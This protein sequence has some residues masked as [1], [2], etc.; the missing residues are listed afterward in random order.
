MSTRFDDSELPVDLR[1]SSSAN[2]S[3]PRPGVR[4]DP[5]KHRAAGLTPGQ[6]MR[7]EYPEVFGRYSGPV[8]RTSQKGSIQGIASETHFARCLGPTGSPAEPIVHCRDE[9]RFYRYDPDEGVYQDLTEHE[10]KRHIGELLHRCAEG[11]K[12]RS[13]EVHELDR[14]VVKRN[15]REALKEQVS[16]SS[17]RFTRDIARLPVANGM[18]DLQKL[19]LESHSPKHFSRWKLSAPWKDQFGVPRRFMEFLAWMFPSRQDRRLAV[20][21]LAMAISGNPAQRLVLLTGDGGTGKSTFIHLLGELVGPRAFGELDLANA[22]Q[23]FESGHWADQLVLHQSEAHTNLLRGNERFLKSISGQDPMEGRVKY[24]RDKIPFVPKALPIIT[25]N[26]SLR[27]RLK[28]DARAWRRRLIVLE[29]DG[30]AL[31]DEEQVDE[32][33]K[34]LLE[35]EGPAILRLIATRAQALLQDGFSGL[36]TTQQARADTVIEGFDPLQVFVD[37]C[38]VEENGAHLYGGELRQVAAEWLRVRDHDVPSSDVGFGRRL[39]PI[40]EEL[41]G[42]KCNSL[43]DHPEYSSSGWRHVRLIRAG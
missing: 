15:V 39:A 35:A 13:G 28:G 10:V 1:P 3:G 22:G 16:V 32:Y 19:E 2:G 26:T 33:H 21:V 30:E 23:R 25:A 4:V 8:F 43:P 40:V 29:T 9:D 5:E 20:D 31:T 17:D 38:V 7:R 42:V 12:E 6:W 27:L 37:E 41:G 36:S 11:S 14:Q 18:L 34:H 24:G